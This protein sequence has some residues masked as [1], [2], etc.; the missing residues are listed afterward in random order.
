M[1]LAHRQ[2]F[3]HHGAVITRVYCMHAFSYTLVYILAA[4]FQ[5]KLHHRRRLSLSDDDPVRSNLSQN[6]PG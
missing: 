5:V 3:T 6:K 1:D 4:N 2:F